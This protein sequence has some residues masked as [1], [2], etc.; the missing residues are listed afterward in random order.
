MVATILFM[1]LALAALPAV[2]GFKKNNP[3]L[4]LVGLGACLVVGLASI[5]A[6]MV[7]AGVLCTVI[8]AMDNPGATSVPFPVEGAEDNAQ[9][10]T[11]G[12]F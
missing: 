9:P 3:K 7:V 2:V 12:Q 8:F 5:L 6:E 11:G 4:A 1:W 10:V